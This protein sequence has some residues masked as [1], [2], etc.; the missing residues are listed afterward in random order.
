MNPFLSFFEGP[1]GA[2]FAVMD[3]Y[4]FLPSA[5]NFTEFSDEMY[6]VFYIKE[7]KMPSERL[8]QMHVD[9]HINEK[10]VLIVTKTEMEE[11]LKARQF[12][13]LITLENKK[14]IDASDTERLDYFKN[15]LP[16]VFPN[17]SKE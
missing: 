11:F 2:A 3:E 1:F 13:D 6:E 17:K 10:E 8:Y 14:L 12:V 4:R 9:S 7:G 16:M 15:W 5:D